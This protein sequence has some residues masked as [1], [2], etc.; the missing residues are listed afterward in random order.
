LFDSLDQLSPPLGENELDEKLALVIGRSRGLRGRRARTRVLAGAL[1]VALVLGAAAVV[2]IRTDEHA[3]ASNRA[4][5]QLVSDVSPSW[6]Q[7]PSVGYTAGFDLNCPSVSTC[8]AIDTEAKQVEVTKDGGDTWQHAALPNGFTPLSELACA[9]PSSCS[10]LGTGGAEHLTMLTTDD[11]AS[12]WITHLVGHRSVTASD[13][14]PVLSCTSPTSCLAAVTTFHGS[15]TAS[16]VIFVTHDGGT[17][18]TTSSLAPGFDPLGGACLSGSCML[19]GLDGHDSSRAAAY[20]SGDDGAGWAQAALPVDV[21]PMTSISCTAPS[22]CFA[23]SSSDVPGSRDPAGVLA[24]TD[25]GQSW[26]ATDTSGLPNSILTSL[27]CASGSSCWA[28]GVV[29]PTG[30]GSVITFADAQGLLASTADG[31][32]SW[33]A[34]RLPDGIR[35]VAQ[36]S[37][38]AA[39]QCFALAYDKPPTGSGSFVLLSRQG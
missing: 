11:G 23:T 17:S 35:A 37:C 16:I 5:W 3:R 7:L 19:V 2:V 4:T 25:A 14:V 38:P 28:S 32:A 34:V 9:G 24:S 36:V 15:S 26:R 6:Q 12:T 22:S 33:Q 30:S 1:S 20:F 31:G 21:G 13:G 10:L 8:F 27:S 18:W 39:T 29:V